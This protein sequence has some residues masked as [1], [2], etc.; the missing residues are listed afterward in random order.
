METV[1]KLRYYGHELI[2]EIDTEIS[3]THDMLDREEWPDVQ[4]GLE[5]RIEQLTDER[6][7]LLTIVEDLQ[8]FG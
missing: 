3:R 8:D 4:D 6:K 2:A 5:A 7:R 1:E